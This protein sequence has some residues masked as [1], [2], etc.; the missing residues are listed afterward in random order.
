MTIQFIEFKRL[1]KL[2][3]KTAKIKVNVNG[4]LKENYTGSLSAHFT[5]TPHHSLLLV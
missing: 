5:F 3:P 4:S 2:L 1:V